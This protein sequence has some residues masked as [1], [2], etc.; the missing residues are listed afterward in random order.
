MAQTS[1]RRRSELC[2]AGLA[3]MLMLTGCGGGQ[4]LGDAIAGNSGSSTPGASANND[5]SEA[6]QDRLNQ[7]RAQRLEN[8]QSEFFTKNGADNAVEVVVTGVGGDPAAASTYLR[9]KLFKAVYFDY[10]N[11]ATKAKQQTE[12]NRKAAADAALAEHQKTWGEGGVGPMWIRFQYKP[13]DSDLPYPSIEAGAASGGTYTFYVSPVVDLNAFAKRFD[14][15]QATNVD[16]SG[17]KVTFQAVLP[18]P[19]PDFDVEELIVQHGAENVATLIVTNA[20]GDESAVGA[21]L[22]RQATQLDPKI[23]LFVVGPKPITRDSYEMTVAP[24][25]DLQVFADRIRFGKVT[26]LDPSKRA[27]TVSADLPNPLP[28]A[29][30][31]AKGAAGAAGE[32]KKLSDWSDFDKEPLEGE[33]KIDW[34]LRIV[35]GNGLYVDRALAELA[36]MPADPKELDRVAEVLN[37]TFTGNGLH[38][39][40]HVDAI[41]N[42][43]TLEGARKIAD[44]ITEDWSNSSSEKYI[45]AIKRMDMPQATDAAADAIRRKIVDDRGGFRLEQN[46]TALERLDRP[47]VAIAALKV[48]VER[49]S[50]SFGNKNAIQGLTRFKTP[51]A[52][53]VLA[54]Q[55]GH[56]WVGNDASV[57]LKQMGDVAEP[58]VIRMLS[59]RAPLVRAEA[60]NIL[61]DVGT[62]KGVDALTA[63][64]ARE[65]EAVVKV[66]LRDARKALV[67]K[68]Q[69]SGT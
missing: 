57:A 42:W 67:Q 22:G 54:S 17:R 55:I 36:A 35:K 14:V 3:V 8:H 32:T 40:R 58:V 23:N 64:V 28:T 44:K 60:A 21:Y 63:A 65:K 38:V 52:A 26:A 6:Y 15:G 66:H 45:A 46:L 39:D 48:L 53:E 25:G 10:A 19:V 68:L 61:Y 18:N 7:S 56:K 24:V 20:A 1:T 41:V 37:A 43:K 34:A 51:E 49:D 69:A 13:V 33:S 29:A 12:A 2:L 9:K 31:A 16:N 27:L 62:Q 5:Q 50:P 59:S 47:D 4:S 11:A 30:L